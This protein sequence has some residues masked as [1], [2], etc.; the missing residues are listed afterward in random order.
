MRSSQLQKQPQVDREDLELFLSLRPRLHYLAARVLKNFANAE[1][2]VQETWIRW[3]ATDRDTV[4]NPQA[5]LSTVTI[6]L[7]LNVVTSAAQRRS[8][9]YAAETI[10]EVDRRTPEVAVETQD[11]IDEA[12]S[13]VLNALTPK[14]RAAFLLHDAFEVPYSEIAEILGKSEPAARQVVSRARRK[15][16][17]QSAV[18]VNV[19]EHQHLVQ[20][21]N[22][23]ASTGDLSDLNDFLGVR[24]GGPSATTPPVSSPIYGAPSVTTRWH[25]LSV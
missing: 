11:E 23:A 12:L 20:A 21:F 4:L 6:R 9:Q 14:E 24:A 7:S 18:V 3:Q 5:F 2:I 10:E 8:T 16:P 22:K 25:A 17:S 19:R 15:L 1:D 13:R